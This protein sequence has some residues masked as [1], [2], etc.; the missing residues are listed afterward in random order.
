MGGSSLDQVSISIFQKQLLHW[1]TQYGR[2]LPWRHTH[3]PYHILVSEIM[4]QQTQVDRVIPKYHDWLKTYP[5]FAAL[6][7]APLEDITR[8]WRPLGYNIRPVRLHHI[9][10]L[11]MKKYHGILPNTYDELIALPGVGP[12]TAGAILS[13][14]FSQD[15]PIVD[16][17]IQRVLLR[18]EGITEDPKRAVIKKR[19][20][21]LAKEMLPKGKA[22]VFNQAFIDFGALIC[23][24]RN[25]HCTPCFFNSNCLSKM[26]HL[27]CANISK[28]G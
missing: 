14:A 18:L 15:A 28:N 21:H 7:I 12:Y 13:F 25:P 20:W 3:N 6:A 19:I 10:Q 8:L 5:T 22:Y 26:Q 11:V 16:T 24:A 9:A 2:D 4:L 23:T 27:K 17:N 1:Y